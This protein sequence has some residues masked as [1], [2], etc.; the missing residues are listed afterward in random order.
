MV[1]T[2][3]PVIMITTR[4][5]T[6][7]VTRVEAATLF[8]DSLE[9]GRKVILALTGALSVVA[10]QAMD[11]MHNVETTRMVAVITVAVLK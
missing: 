4:W 1:P 10:A 3:A 6:R 5:L 11:T 7:R 8:A 2:Q 9:A